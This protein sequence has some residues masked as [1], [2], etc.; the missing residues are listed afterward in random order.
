ML[1]AT[2]PRRSCT[3]WTWTIVDQRP[4]T[5]LG[6]ATSDADPPGDIAGAARPGDS[7]HSRALS[8]DNG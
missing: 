8:G 1:A 6:A 3:D 5:L 7:C 2:R 4:A